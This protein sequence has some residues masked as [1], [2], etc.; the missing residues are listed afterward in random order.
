MS[1]NYAKTKSRS[2]PRPTEA[3]RTFT[4]RE[5]NA[6][7]PLVRAIVADLVGLARDVTERRQRLLAL[8]P[9]GERRSAD[10]YQEE[11]VQAGEELER[12]S[13]RVLEYVKEL[14]DLGIE[15]KSVTEGLV[16]FPAILSGR[17]VYLCWKLGEPEVGFWHE[18]D[19]GFRGRQPLTTTVESSEGG[20]GATGL[21]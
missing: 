20:D 8:A 15:T 13:R 19:A 12:D 21:N 5:A 2:A 1:G 18:M 7:L 16:D 3:K 4:I 6:T 17:M 11:L 9:S 14:R 10:P